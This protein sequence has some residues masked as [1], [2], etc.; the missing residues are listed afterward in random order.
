MLLR[1]AGQGRLRVFVAVAVLVVLSGCGV[2]VATV[3]GKVTLKGRQPPE[4]ATISFDDV[5]THHNAS[6]PIGADGSYKLTSGEGEGLRPGKY[7]VSV[8]P[9][10]AKDSSEP[11]PA[12]TFHAKYQNPATSGLEKEVKSGTNEFNFELDPPAVAAAGS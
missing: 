2:R 4:R 8:Q 10:Y 7:K 6:S 11:R 5:D 9:P 1:P 3:T 12:P